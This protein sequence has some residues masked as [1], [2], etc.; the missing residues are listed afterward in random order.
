MIHLWHYSL[1]MRLGTIPVQQREY[2]PVPKSES[3]V[4]SA[5]VK[6]KVL[7][8]FPCPVLSFFPLRLFFHSFTLVHAQ[9]SPGKGK[10]E[11]P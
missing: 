11:A 8:P 7:S 9:V 10:K 1:A 2:S 5:K 3:S 6:K 4:F